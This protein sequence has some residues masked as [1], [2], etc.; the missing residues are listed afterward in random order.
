MP[1][2]K[3]MI[4]ILHNGP[5]Y[6]KGGITGPILTPYMEDVRTIFLMITRGIKVVEVLPDGNEITLNTINFDSPPNPLKVNE[7]K[8]VEVEKKVKKE[9]PVIPNNT[10]Q[11]PGNNSF[12]E[13]DH[14]VIVNQNNNNNRYLKKNI[15][16]DNVKKK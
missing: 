12:N 6:P 15:I 7:E 5:I 8:I 13:N 1:V 3:K 10:V 11:T 2:E 16:P 4:K 9:Q 14:R